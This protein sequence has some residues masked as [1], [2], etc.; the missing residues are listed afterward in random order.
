M[1]KWIYDQDAGHMLVARFSHEK[2]SCSVVL[3]DI[4]VILILTM[5]D[6]SY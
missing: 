2:V 3:T 5:A 6:F 1:N 4:Y